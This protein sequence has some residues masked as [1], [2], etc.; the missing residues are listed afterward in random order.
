MQDQQNKN[1]QENVC[2]PTHSAKSAKWMGHPDFHPP[3]VGKAGGR[4]TTVF[5][6]WQLACPR[7]SRYFW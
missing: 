1:R 6:I 3:R 7:F 4:L 2:D 5:Q